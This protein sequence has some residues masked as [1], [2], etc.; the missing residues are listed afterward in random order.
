MKMKMNMKM[1]VPILESTV[2]DPA[3]H[4]RP[5][6]G[7]ARAVGCVRAWCRWQCGLE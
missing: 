6:S 2:A 7:G 3:T 4:A 1:K 5:V